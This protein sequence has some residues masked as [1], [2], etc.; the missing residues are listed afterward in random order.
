[1]EAF[2]LSKLMEYFFVKVVK[3][4]QT[5]RAKAFKLQCNIY[6][7]FLILTKFNCNSLK[8]KKAQSFD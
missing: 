1:M 2:K 6:V 5:N 7:W 4:K 3:T 8:T